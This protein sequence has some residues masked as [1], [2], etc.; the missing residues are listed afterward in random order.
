[1]WESSGKHSRGPAPRRGGLGLR[2]GGSGTRGEDLGRLAGGGEE[3][4][5]GRPNINWGSKTRM[6]YST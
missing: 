1:M 3:G 6:L 5:D 2:G 4:R